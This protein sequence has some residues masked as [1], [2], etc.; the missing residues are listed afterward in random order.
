MA[1]DALKAIK[2]GRI[3]TDFDL[4][5]LIVADSKEELDKKK[6][7]I[8]ASL[9]QIKIT[10][11]IAH[12]QAKTFIRSFIDGNPL[13]YYN[14]ADLLYPLSFQIDNGTYVGDF[15]SNYA[16]PVIGIS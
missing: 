13:E 9:G 12:N 2:N 3:L 10:A 1:Y 11:R 7:N 8:I 14:T 16:S 6:K 4:N 15:D 5:I